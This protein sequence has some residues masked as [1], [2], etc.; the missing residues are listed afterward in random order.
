MLSDFGQGREEARAIKP[1]FYFFLSSTMYRA[2]TIPRAL[3]YTRP[4]RDRFSL[5]F[6]PFPPP[7]L[8]SWIA[9]RFGLDY[10][11]PAR[12]PYGTIFGLRDSRLRVRLSLR[13][14]SDFPPPGRAGGD[15]MSTRSRRT[16][17]LAGEMFNGRLKKSAV[18]GCSVPEVTLTF[19]MAGR[20]D[21]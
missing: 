7:D 21:A 14:P 17:V 5:A 15:S 10:P 8:S 4:C 18:T 12:V 1:A 3:S 2:I 16:V 9:W 19:H 20:P 6:A 13:F 11:I